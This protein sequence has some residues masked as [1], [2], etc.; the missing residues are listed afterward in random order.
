MPVT[1]SQHAQGCYRMQSSTTQKSTAIQKFNYFVPIKKNTDYNNHS[2]FCFEGSLLP[3]KR[4]L[5]HCIS[6]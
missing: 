2:F 3:Q 4:Q 1:N 5:Q 6:M